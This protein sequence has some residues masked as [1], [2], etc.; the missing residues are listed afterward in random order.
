[1]AN[2]DHIWI[3]MQDKKTIKIVNKENMIF[4]YIRIFN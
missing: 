3:C 4:I 2:P 1:M